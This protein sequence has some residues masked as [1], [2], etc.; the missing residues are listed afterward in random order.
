[1]RDQY[2]AACITRRIALTAIVG[3]A[4]GVGYK[5]RPAGTLSAS[6]SDHEDF[7]AS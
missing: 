1:M 5:R 3:L 2:T 6:R 4:G 7:F